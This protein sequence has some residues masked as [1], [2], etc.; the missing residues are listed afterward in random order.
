MCGGLLNVLGAD[1]GSLSRQGCAWIAG[2]ELK[3]KPQ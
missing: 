1:E 3:R 2:I